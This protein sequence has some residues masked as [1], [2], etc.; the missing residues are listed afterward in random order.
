MK[1]ILC[2]LQLGCSAVALAA[3]TIIPV[4]AQQGM[5]VTIYNENR[6]LIKDE[7]QVNL[8]AGLNELAFQ[9]VSANMMP[10]TALLKGKGLSTREQNFNFDLL[11][12]DALLKKS[13]GQKVT[14][15]YID[16]ATG[17]N[18]RETAEVLAYNNNK[19]VLKIEGK[20][21]TDYPGRVIFDS[22]PENLR[23]E[24]TLTI[25]AVADAAGAETVEL[26]YLTTGLSWK[27]DYVAKLNADES[28]MSLNGFVTLTNHSGADYKK[29]LLQLVAGDV[30]VV[31]EYVE[32]P[33]MLMAKAAVMADGMVSNEMEAEALTDF[34]IYTVPHKTDLLSNQTKQVALLSAADIGVNKTYELNQPFGVYDTEVKRMK[35][36]IYVS[37]KNDEKNRLGKPLPKGTIRLYKEDS[38]GNMQFVGEDRINHTADKETVRLRL[39]TSFNLSADM[40]RT[41]FKKLSEKIQ[42]GTY[43]VTF[44][45]GSDAGADVQLSLNFPNDFKLMEE[46]L[47]GNRTTSNTVK[48]V[49]S[50]PAKGEAQLTFK[51]Q[52]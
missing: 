9:G 37:F 30:N 47:K 38:K 27:A 4:S 20:I 26:D 39:G 25:S 40:K 5:N 3:E 14:V 28:K 10:Q 1:S 52:Y 15:E 23:A 13:V 50:V 29:A 42:Q 12:K 16:P 6:A 46:S 36:D 34:Y 18:S 2:L 51:V 31:R 32:R 45:N 8:V 43:E 33:R 11:T 22:I 49:V 44:K 24:P 35:P 7:R 48:W 19:P 17:K 41:A 21:E